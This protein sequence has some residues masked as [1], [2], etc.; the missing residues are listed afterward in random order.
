MGGRTS[1]AALHRWH[2]LILEAATN[3][4][5]DRPDQT[6]AS[7]IDAYLDHA[8]QDLAADTHVRRTRYL[9]MF[10]EAHGFRLVK[11]CLPIHLTQWLDGKKAVGVRLDAG[12][13][14][15]DRAAG[16]QLGI[17]AAAHS[18]QSVLWR[19]PATGRTAPAHDG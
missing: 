9:Q 14:H 2:E 18:V 17:P 15:Q 1:Q 6:V 10:A 12:D 19:Y 8:K 11:E 4:S 16:V 13:G 3:P 7:V 5:V